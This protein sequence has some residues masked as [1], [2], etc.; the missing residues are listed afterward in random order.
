MDD[1]IEPTSGR[2]LVVD[3]SEFTGELLACTLGD[4]GWD[5]AVATTGEAALVLAEELRPDVV[6]CDFHMPGMDGLEVARRLAKLDA[7]LPI[8]MLTAADEADLGADRGRVFDIIQKSA[9]PGPLLD[10]VGRAAA[11][12]RLARERLLS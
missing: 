11:H 7:T 4:H 3:D 9:D 5:V 2:V 8:V 10:T 1:G 6:V 12:A